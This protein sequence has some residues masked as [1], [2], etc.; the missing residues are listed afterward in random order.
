MRDEIEEDLG[1]RGGQG[2]TASELHESSLLWAAMILAAAVCLIVLSG[3]SYSSRPSA[4]CAGEGSACE[5][6]D[7]PN[8]EKLR[9]RIGGL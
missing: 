7:R 3:C 4:Y 8:W 6:P 5:R 1:I 2:R 9:Q